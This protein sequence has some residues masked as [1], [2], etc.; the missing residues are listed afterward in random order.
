EK[1]QKRGNNCLSSAASQ[2]PGS[3]SLCSINIS[4]LFHS[5]EMPLKGLRGLEVMEKL[6]KILYE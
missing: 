2:L 1:L 4:K 6:H 5:S 3:V